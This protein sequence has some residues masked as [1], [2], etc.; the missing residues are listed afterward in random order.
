[1][2]TCNGVKLHIFLN[3]TVDVGE[4]SSSRTVRFNSKERV[5]LLT[6]YTTQMEKIMFCHSPGFEPQMVKPIS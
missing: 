5:P 6:V 3:A 4:K 1:M 2:K